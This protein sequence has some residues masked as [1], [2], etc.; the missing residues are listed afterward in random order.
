MFCGNAGQ[1]IFLR[2]KDRVLFMGLLGKMSVRFRIEMHA[3]VLMNNHYHLLIRPR[4]KNLSRGM[5][6]L[7]TSYTRSFNLSNKRIGHLF[8]G[9]FKNIVV[10]NDDDLLRLSCHIDRNPLRAGIVERLIDYRWYSYRFYGYGRKPP[11]WLTTES[12]L[13]AVGGDRTRERY[14]RMVQRYSDETEKSGGT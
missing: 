6:W 3:Y 8:Q 14:R 10:E 2:D 4:E 11:A 5:Q 13:N 1:D 9:R 7:G 12:I